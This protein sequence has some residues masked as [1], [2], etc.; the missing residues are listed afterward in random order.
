VHRD[1]RFEI[2]GPG[3]QP[4]FDAYEQLNRTYRAFDRYFGAPAPRLSVVLF[5]PSSKPHNAAVESTLRE[6]GATVLRYVRPFR[7]SLRERVGDDGY[8]GALWPVGPSATRIL[9]A[10]TASAA[11][12]PDTAALRRF[13]AWYR[14]AV[15]SIVGDGTSLPVDVEYVKENRA[16]RWTLEQLTAIDRPTSADSALDPYLRDDA[17]DRD[18]MFA[19]QSSALMQFLLEREGPATVATLGHGFAKGETF[20]EQVKRFRVLPTAIA[21]LDERWLAWLAAQHPIW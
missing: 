14:T 13:P 18:R 15:M 5:D 12:A 19:S 1:P 20:A 2:F 10:S 9:L 3:S 6:R 17:S 16:S 7:S 11:T 21:E 4:V 8:E